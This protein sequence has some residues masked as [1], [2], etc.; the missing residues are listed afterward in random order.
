MSLPLNDQCLFVSGTGG[1]RTHIIRFKK[2]VHYLVCHDPNTVKYTQR[3]WAGGRSNPR[4]RFF[5]PLLCRLSYRPNEKS[6]MS[7]VTPG[8]WQSC[9]GGAA[10]CHKRKGC[11]GNAFA[12]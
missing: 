6:P 9:V 4:L 12:A 10:R 11:P 1:Y 7:L 5:R 8:F 2:P 3:K